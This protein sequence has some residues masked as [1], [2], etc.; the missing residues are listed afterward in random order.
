MDYLIEVG[1]RIRSNRKRLGISQQELA[2]AAGYDSGKG[3]ISRIESGQVNMTMDKL[4][5][6]AKYLGLKPSD[7]LHEEEPKQKVIVVEGLSDDNIKRV[8][9]FT[10]MLKE[11]EE[12]RR[13]N[14]TGK[15]GD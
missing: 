3:M 12:W 10:K 2:E 7:L 9:E 13:Q 15:D 14:G 5:R 6:I 8:E 4:I 1:E 11:A